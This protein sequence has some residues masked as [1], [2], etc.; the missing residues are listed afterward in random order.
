MKNLVIILAFFSF[1]LASGQSDQNEYLEAKRLLAEGQFGSAQAAF[2]SLKSSKSF[3]QYAKF[4]F[5]LSAYKQGDVK[6]ATDMW[7]QLLLQYPNWNQKRELF[8][9][10]SLAH[11]EEKNFAKALDYIENYSKE[12]SSKDLEKQFIHTYLS[13][14][15]AETLKTIFKKNQN[16]FLAK[17]LVKKLIEQPFSERDPRFINNLI[18]LVGE[19][20]LNLEILP[21]NIQESYNVAVM[22][23]F[24]YDSLH[25]PGIVLN[26]S[27]VTDLY[28]GMLL[29]A[30]M[31]GSLG[32][33]LNLFPFD[34][35]RDANVTKKLLS[36]NDINQYDLIVGPLYPEPNDVVNNFSQVNNINKI[37]PISGNSKVLGENPYAF[38]FMPSYETMAIALANQAKKSLVNKTGMIFYEQNERDSLFA[39]VFRSELEKD[40]A[41]QIV[42]FEGLNKENARSWLDTLIAQYDVYWTRAEADSLKSEGNLLRDRRL[43]DDELRV[44]HALRSKKALPRNKEMSPKE[45]ARFLN[46]VSYDKEGKPIFYYDKAFYME[47][48]SIGFVLGSTRKNHLANNLI[49]VI[50]TR[51]DSTQLY[52]LGEWIEFTMVSYEQLERIA[53]QLA[54]SQYVDVSKPDFTYVKK[55]IYERYSG[56][57]TIFHFVGYELMVQLGK[58]MQEHGEYFQIGLRSGK[59]IN[60]R[61]LEAM[62]YGASNDNQVVPI[63]QFQNSKLDIVNKEEYDD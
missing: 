46:L 50:E 8:Y 35:K 37:N 48:D 7:K 11:F 47:K 40:T 18:K 26:N 30:E 10:L 29:G 45:V 51:G 42:V 36:K 63:V 54:Y 58:L 5:A 1:S 41:F 25:D 55:E 20:V 39:S 56:Y 17:I 13:E 59:L 14:L 4:Y 49:S 31:A 2:A 44:L 61:V 53:V 33:K 43:N 27:L 22:L 32:I 9:W 16:N 6:T 19:D 52:G 3:G 28:Q 57:P 21:K 60:G 12:T 34:T 24:M 38:L 15:D 23:P 62:K